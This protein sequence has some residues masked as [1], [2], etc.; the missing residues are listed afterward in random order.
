MNRESRQKIGEVIE[1]E[2]GNLRGIIVRKEGQ[3]EYEQYFGGGNRHKRY[4]VASVTKSI[5]SALA[6]IAIDQG[7]INSIEDR[8]LDFFPEYAAK[9]END[10]RKKVTLKHLLTMTAP[11][12]YEDWQEPLE[13]L[14]TSPDWPVFTID[15]LGERGAS[16]PQLG[17]FQ[18][19]TSG[20]HL[21]SAILTRAAGMCAREFA[22]RYL[23]Q[24][25]ELDPIA[26][27]PMKGYCFE[28]LFGCSLK[29]WVH[30]P[31]G[32]ST[33]GWGL[34]MTAQEMARIGQLYLNRGRWGTRQVI[35]ED[36][37]AGSTAANEH[38]YG[39]MWWQLKT[40]EVKAF[41]AMGDGG[42]MICCIPELQTVIAIVSDF[43]ADAK[44]RWELVT[45][46]ILPAMGHGAV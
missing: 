7:R 14:C 39:Y 34:T 27:Y 30:D 35:S 13:A 19:S 36:W 3:V 31:Q 37:V 9:Q 17:R 45:D 40:A 12:P 32:N 18:Y 8:V 23:Y 33:G 43:A 1:Q 10:I 16:E 4:H 20:A 15:M 25:L 26:D 42:N 11:Y 38:H 22:N 21:L 41:A 44:D 24:P 6:G 46:H 29:G 28:D 5:L 2:Y